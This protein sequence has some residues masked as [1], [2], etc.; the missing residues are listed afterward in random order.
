MSE[1]DLEGESSEKEIVKTT[2]DLYMY[3]LRTAKPCDAIPRAKR[4]AFVGK[5]LFASD[6]NMVSIN[7]NDILK[8]VN[9]RQQNHTAQTSNGIIY[10]V[11]LCLMSARSI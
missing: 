7:E 6:G 11:V 8:W 9:G 4:G 5:T 10:A 1:N 2:G 3:L